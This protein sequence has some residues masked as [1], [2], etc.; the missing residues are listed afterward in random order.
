[1]PSSAARRRRSMIFMGLS[2]AATA[3]GLIVLVAILWTLFSRG[4]AAINWKMFTEMT[5]PPGASG[6]LANAIY[7]SLVM[8]LVS[9]VIA[10]PLGIMAGTALNEFSGNGKLAAT[11][12]FINDVLLSAPSIIIGLF[13]YTIMV[14]TM[15]HFSAWAGSVALALIALPLI[16]RT[17]QEMLALVPVALREAAAA[18]GTP[19]WKI[20]WSVVWKSAASGLLTAVL[21]AFARV[22]GETA[23]LLFTAL[24]NQFWTANMNAPMA[25]L[26]VIIFQYAMS[27]YDDWQ[28]LA[29]GGALIITLTIL[30]INL[31][32]R[33]LGARRKV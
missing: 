3:I 2:V 5:P 21:L 13:V 22:A 20:M 16:V 18:L 10:A 23:P 4:L 1:M 27:P 31:V 30:V 33:T 19:R 32:A 14:V 17:T 15:G 9:L 12:S 26:P 28:S 8:T 7:G 25:N 6:G 24:S 11:A 29:W